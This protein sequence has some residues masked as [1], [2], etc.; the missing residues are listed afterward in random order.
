MA[1]Y[2]F[3]NYITNPYAQDFVLNASEFISTNLL[4]AGGNTDLSVSSI[5]LNY[6]LSG[7]MSSGF[8]ITLSG[9]SNKSFVNPFTDELGGLPTRF[10]EFHI[11]GG[12][13]NQ[14][15]YFTSGNTTPY[16]LQSFIGTTTPTTSPIS[17]NAFKLGA[18]GATASMSTTEKVL[19]I[20]SYFQTFG[21][22][23][24]SIGGYLAFDSSL[25]YS[26]TS[27]ARIGLPDNHTLTFNAESSWGMAWTTAGT[28]AASMN[29]N[30]VFTFA[31]PVKTT[32]TH[33]AFIITGAAHTGQSASTEV[34]DINLNLSATL[35]HATGALSLQRSI[36]I[37]PRTYSFVGSS[38]VSS[39]G[40]LYL[41]APNAGTNAVFTDTWALRL[42]T[43][44]TLGASAADMQ[45]SAL[46]VPTHTLTITGSTQNI[47]TDS[48]FSAVNIGAISITDVSAVTI[49]NVS[50]IYIA[51]APAASGS[52]TITNRYSI[53]ADDGL[54]RFDGG[55]AIDGSTSKNVL[56]NT[57]TPTR[58]AET[59]LDSNVTMTEAQY[60]RVGN[61]VTVSGR[62]TADPT[63]TATT[64]SFEITLPVSSNIGSAEDVAGTATCGSIASMSA[65]VIGVA[66]NDTAKI[67][68]KSTDV[69]SQTWSYVFVYQVI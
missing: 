46:S 9:V 14:F 61:T 69:T 45:Y 43:A 16:K 56:S 27:V 67:Q 10:S 41:G 58:S 63:L 29:T 44:T 21:D 28:S 3:P 36:N 55:I 22:G 62:F 39:V 4:V 38:T 25:T 31:P 59:N 12:A 26:T 33:S 5:A 1:N 37:Q 47:R 68:W 17:L 35:Q 11:H 40:T 24:V 48:A 50:S 64:T 2:L 60:C 51:G 8:P 42:G 30:G 6:E 53:W 65:E 49:D 66:A 32:S 19:N 57:Y 20:N 7:D 18:A 13:L 34:V 15:S 54:A 52:V 23:S